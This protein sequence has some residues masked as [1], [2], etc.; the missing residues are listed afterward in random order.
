MS[1]S[2]IN[3]VADDERLLHW[4]LKECVIY[5]VSLH[6]SKQA[7]RTRLVAFQ[8]EEAII[9]RLRPLRADRH[10]FSAK[11]L[12][13]VNYLL[14]ILP[15]DSSPHIRRGIE[16]GFGKGVE[17]GVRAE[18]MIRVVMGHEDSYHRAGGKRFGLFDYRV[19]VCDEE[20]WIDDDGCFGANDYASNRRQTCVG[21]DVVV[22]FEGPGRPHLG[23]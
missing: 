17:D 23:R 6:R 2:C 4:Q 22:D 5:A 21:G 7:D 12:W 20:G 18:V 9:I 8:D 10:V 1:A 3:R 16:L 15:V 13:P 14:V 19:C 11:G